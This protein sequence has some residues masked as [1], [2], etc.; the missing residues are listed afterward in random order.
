M[1]AGFGVTV[2]DGSALGLAAVPPQRESDS[3]AQLIVAG[4]CVTVRLGAPAW[5]TPALRLGVRSG[6]TVTCCA[7]MLDDTSDNNSASVMRMVFIVPPMGY[8]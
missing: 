3:G 6:D 2:H 1:L 4:P 5:F 7:S 8:A